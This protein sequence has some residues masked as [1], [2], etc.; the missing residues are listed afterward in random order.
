VVRL[1]QDLLE[2]GVLVPAVRYPTVKRGQAR[3]RVSLSA[4]HSPADCALLVKALS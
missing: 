4:A 3:L 1:S 2:R